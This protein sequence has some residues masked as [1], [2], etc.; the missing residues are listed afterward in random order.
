MSVF[1]LL[2]SVLGDTVGPEV[3]MRT[4]GNRDAPGRMVLQVEVKGTANVQIQG[5]LAR[6]APWQN[7]GPAYSGSELIH[8]DAVQ[9]LRA[10]SS[11]MVASSN[12]SVWAVW[13]W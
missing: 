5:R 7:I 12:V 4:V 13:G 2:K 1:L 6:D 3:A 9:F 8:I 10:V 11:G